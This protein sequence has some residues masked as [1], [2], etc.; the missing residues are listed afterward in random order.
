VKIM[1]I[2]RHDGQDNDD[3]GAISHA[4]EQLGHE[5]LRVHEDPRK[6]GAS[7]LE[8]DPDLVLFHKWREFYLLSQFECPCIMWYWDLVSS[9]DPKFSKRVAG[10]EGRMYQALEHCD[11]AFVSDGDFVARD[12]T[13]K[14]RHMFQGADERRMTPPNN[15]EKVYPLL[16]T[17]MVHGHTQTRIDHLNRLRDKYR[18]KLKVV[19]TP[20]RVHGEKLAHLLS[21]SAIAI[22]PLGATS[23]YYW[24]NRVYLT[25]GLGG[26]LLHPYCKQLTEHY[27]PDK[28]LV[29]YRDHEDCEWVIDY[30]LRHPEERHQIA[31]AAYERTLQEHTYR[32]RC[33]EL[34]ETVENEL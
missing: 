28:E 26:F 13:G 16:F 32:H 31:S 25:I 10:R 22:A 18:D 34:L 21:R 8:Q 7:P 11:M 12:R 3:E 27:V 15:G 2:A 6:R 29:Y 33:Q 20:H 4:L 17:G 1:H 5:V 14:C 9:S 19:T 30:Y 23:D 24:S